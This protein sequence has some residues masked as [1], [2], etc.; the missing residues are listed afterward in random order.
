[1]TNHTTTDT[2][3]VAIALTRHQTPQ[4]STS[5]LSTN[6]VNSTAVATA[7]V[8]KPP[9]RALGGVVVAHIPVLRF[10]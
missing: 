2:T 10:E 9:S 6:R 8:G 7:G 1:V 3:P 4:K 5:R